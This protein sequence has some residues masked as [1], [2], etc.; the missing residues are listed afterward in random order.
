M[1]EC[2]LQRILIT[3]VESEMICLKSSFGIPHRRIVKPVVQALAKWSRS[4]NRMM[5]N[6]PMVK[7]SVQLFSMGT[8]WAQLGHRMGT[9]QKGSPLVSLLF[10]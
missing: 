1:T 6:H 5:G 2:E 8:K 7:I 9:K 4:L 3:S 10:K